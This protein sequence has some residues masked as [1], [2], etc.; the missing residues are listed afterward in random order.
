MCNETLYPLFCTY[1]YF[2]E[3]QSK[4]VKFSFSFSHFSLQWHLGHRKRKSKPV[5][6]RISI[7]NFSS[8]SRSYSFSLL[9]VVSFTFIPDKQLVRIQVQTWW[10]FSNSKFLMRISAIF[11]SIVVIDEIPSIEFWWWDYLEETNS[12]IN[13]IDSSWT[14][15]T[16]THTSDHLHDLLDEEKVNEI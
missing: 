11:W 12:L 9:R 2:R 4:I 6:R 3:K 5:N 15:D 10:R 16:F 7:V 1:V 14:M 8:L 13:E